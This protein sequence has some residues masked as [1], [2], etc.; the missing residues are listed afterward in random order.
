MTRRDR[1]WA[2]CSLL[3]PLLLLL[4]A[5]APPLAHGLW[6]SALRQQPGSPASSSSG[7][8]AQELRQAPPGN[9]TGNSTVPDKPAVFTDPSTERFI[10]MAVNSYTGQVSA[11]CPLLSRADHDNCMALMHCF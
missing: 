1:W 3:P 11:S 9:G 5:A 2:A 7:A 4:V 10:H 6:A 8:A